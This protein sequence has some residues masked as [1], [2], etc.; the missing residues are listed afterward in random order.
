LEL[1]KIYAPQAKERQG[2]RTDISADV[3]LKLIKEKTS[4]A[5]A[6]ELFL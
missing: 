4:Y 5:V 2:T 1:E 6:R 3:T